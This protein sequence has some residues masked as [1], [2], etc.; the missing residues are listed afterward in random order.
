MSRAI[1]TRLRTSRSCADQTAHFQRTLSCA[2]SHAVLPHGS[3][4]R[5]PCNPGMMCG[6]LVVPRSVMLGSLTMM[7]GSMFVVLRC[8]FM[9]LVDLDLCHSVLPDIFWLQERAQR[10]R[11]P[12]KSGDDH[13]PGEVTSCSRSCYASRSDRHRC[14]LA[15]L[16]ASLPASSLVR[17]LKQ[18]FGPVAPAV[19]FVHWVREEMDQCLARYSV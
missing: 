2:F 7:L 17:L 9:M 14:K 12:E 10:A 8:L 4:A 3:G 15:M 18:R 5:R 1:R 6:L 19:K 16:T 11:N 13:R